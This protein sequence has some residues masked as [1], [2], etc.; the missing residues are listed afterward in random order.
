MVWG[1]VGQHMGHMEPLQKILHW[2]WK[3]RN[4]GGK[5]MTAQNTEPGAVEDK[6]MSYR[7]AA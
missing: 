7:S 5:V 6:S 1:F 2:E 3:Y 4:V